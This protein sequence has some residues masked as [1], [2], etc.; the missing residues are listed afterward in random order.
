[1]TKLSIVGA[2]YVG[3]VSA[4]CYAEKGYSVILREIDQRKYEAI[5]QGKPP[6][7]EPLIDDALKRSLSSGKLVVTKDMQEAVLNSHIVF[8]AVGT[9]GKKDGSIDLDQVRLAAKE[10]GVTLKQA[11][12]YHHVVVRSTVVPGTTSKIVKPILQ[13]ASGKNIGE[14]FGLAVNPEFLREGSAVHDTYHPDR[15]IIGDLDPKTGDFLEEF[16]RNFHDGKPPPI[17]RMSSASAEI[18]KYASNAFL[19]T[20]ISFINEIA[21]ICESVNDADVVQVA[22]AIGLDTRIGRKFLDAGL[23][24]GGSCFPKDVRALVAASEGCNYRPRLLKAVLDINEK[25]ALNAVRLALEE[26]HS[27]RQKRIAVLGLSFKPETD[28]MREARS[29]VVIERLLKLG[30]KVVVYDPV[31]NEK[32]RRL[33]R[34]KIEYARSMHECIRGADCC[35]MVT[36]WDEFQRL[37][38]EDFLSLM[39]RPV[40]VDGRRIY[41]PCSFAKKVR[42]RAIGLANSA[43][44]EEP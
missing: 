3:L 30:A 31:A 21:N 26:L 38:A 1:L 39:R 44:S 19:A 34:G 7:H 29:M 10:I 17:L 27:L 20:K 42:Y 25:Q 11:E 37:T 2:G 16:Y 18:A 15:I 9:P 8:V 12:G 32:A 22:D 28:D 33:L 13:K 36:E 5:Q 43:S 41:K 35:I 23:G 4:C 40:V 6:F 14:K 24:F